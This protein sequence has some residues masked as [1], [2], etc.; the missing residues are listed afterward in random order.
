MQSS[1]KPNRVVRINF[2]SIF[3]P[4]QIWSISTLG[5]FKSYGEVTN[6]VPFLNQER[7]KVRQLLFLFELIVRQGKKLLF[8][9]KALRKQA[10]GEVA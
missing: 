10:E 3:V 1:I 9:E 5:R 7:I 2:H 6:I 4:L 8:L